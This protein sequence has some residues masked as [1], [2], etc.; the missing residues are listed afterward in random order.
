MNNIRIRIL[1]AWIITTAL[2]LSGSWLRE[3]YLSSNNNNNN[4]RSDT[5]RKDDH[6]GHHLNITI[7][8]SIKG[9]YN[10]TGPFTL[11][12]NT[13]VKNPLFPGWY[14]DPEIHFFENRF[15]IYPTTSDNYDKQTFFE[16]F[17]SSDLIN[18]TNEGKK[19]G[20]SANTLVD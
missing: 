8:S 10:S 3:G 12:P 18:W 16:A 5:S 7:A 2:Y 6:D 19:I 4:N 15:W 13:V 1:L 9:R 17:S 11:A 14:A 20:F